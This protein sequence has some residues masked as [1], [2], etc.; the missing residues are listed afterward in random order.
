MDCRRT[1]WRI[2]HEKKSKYER[3]GS[4][5]KDHLDSRQ[6]VAARKEHPKYEL[7]CRYP[8]A[9]KSVGKTS[10]QSSQRSKH[11]RRHFSTDN[12]L[13][14]HQKCGF[15]HPSLSP[16]PSKRQTLRSPPRIDASVPDFGLMRGFCRVNQ[17]F[18]QHLG[19]LTDR[20]RLFYLR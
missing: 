17:R 16:I 14:A 5:E 20:Q 11:F 10:E 6:K 1:E 12:H 18:S 7:S 15:Q 9:L 2:H 13:K 3:E 4:H 19:H 8:C